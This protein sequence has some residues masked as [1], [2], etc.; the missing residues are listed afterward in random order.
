MSQ[1]YKDG[2]DL[3][4]IASMPFDKFKQQADEQT[5]ANKTAWYGNFGDQRDQ[6]L[7]LLYD[8]AMERFGKPEQPKE[9][10]KE[11]EK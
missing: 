4:H 9:I 7:Q 11:K 5:K 10:K 2:Y 6:K 1:Q 3:K 8:T